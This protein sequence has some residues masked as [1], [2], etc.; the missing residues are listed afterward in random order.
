MADKTPKTAYIVSHTHW[1][2]EWRYP[3][4]ESTL[5]LTD[6]I[7]ELIELM[8]NDSCPAFLM[9]GQVAPVLDYLDVRP[10]MLERVKKLVASGK[11]EIG[12]WMT[13]PDEFPVDG[14]ALVRNLLMGGEAAERLGQVLK[15]GYTPFGWGQTAQLPQ[16]YAGF[17][18]DTVFM[19]KRVNEKRAPKSEFQ[20]KG[21][22][23][24]TLL[25]SRFGEKGRQNFYFLIH[26][27]ALFGMDF[28]SPDWAHHWSAQNPAWRRADPA[29]SDKNL[30]C[31]KLSLPENLDFLDADRLE[32]T[33]ETTNPS[34]IDDHRVMMNGCDF[35]A[36]QPRLKDIVERLNELDPEREWK[37]A[38]LTEFAQLLREKIAGMDLP[39]VEGE[40]RDGPALLTSGNALST[41]L[42]IKTLNKKA[43]NLLIRFA[44]PLATLAARLGAPYP[45][46]FLKKAWDF[47]IFSHCHDS[48]NGV[49]QDKTVRDVCYRLDQVVELAQTIGNRAIQ[50]M[51]QRM[52]LKAEKDDDVFLTVF[53]PLPHP[54]REILEAAPMVEGQTERHKEWTLD[55]GAQVVCDEKGEPCP[56]QWMGRQS[57][58]INAVE[59]HTR[60]HP[61]FCTRHRLF[62]DTGEIPAGGYKVFRLKKKEEAKELPEIWADTQDRSGTLLVAP[63]IMENAFLRV[64]VNPNGSFNLLDKERDHQYHNLNT[65]EDRA[66]HGDYWFNEAPMM[67]ET[68]SSLGCQARVWTLEEGPLQTTLVTEVEMPVPVRADRYHSRRTPESAPL[69]IRTFLTLRH[70]QRR[71]DLRVEFENTM[72]DHC[73][74]ALYPTNLE[75]AEYAD[76]GGHFYVDRRPIRPQGPD[77]EKVWPG[78]ATL[79]MQ[80]FLDVSDGQSGLAFLQDSLTEYEVSDTPK[81][82]V[83]L[84]LLRAVQNWL[85]VERKGDFH[86]DQKGSQCLGFHSLSFAIM[87]H[88]GNWQDAGIDREAEA[89]NAPLF[90]V[91]STAQQGNLPGDAA[92]FLA[93]SNPAL[94]FSA[95]KKTESRDSWTLRLYNPTSETQQAELVLKPVPDAVWRLDLKEERGE[96]LPR[97]ED[98]TISLTVKPCQIVTLE[99]A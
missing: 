78:M 2:R 25:T 32:K 55:F 5:Y 75:K 95:L 63:G 49:T 90:P 4:W 38:T 74:R 83:A 99:L 27:P 15:V 9:D 87:P 20:W 10:E 86:P 88:S 58:V 21:P 82:V 12:P 54:R 62:F 98:G 73:L 57:D 52:D 35:A 61:Y 94:R 48:I 28:E 81:R 41:R 65:F 59:L 85:A 53:N 70:N 51:L 14:E 60:P 69:R 47:L 97:N 23:G 40:L 26:L 67:P 16:I 13:L 96:G 11:L 72:E 92:S 1:D 50:E 45:E 39:T 71:L 24:T 30:F 36:A 29:E 22:D 43:Q 3:V 8:E 91:Q 44:E 6:F 42:Y 46:T 68:V 17:G 79:P 18:I 34:V 80:Q 37:P 93:L 76:T 66:E 7:D 31:Q 56:T 19:G 33:W 89:F 64:C 84:T 77:A